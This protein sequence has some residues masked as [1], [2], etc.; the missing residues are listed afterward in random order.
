[1]NETELQEASTELGGAMFP[2]ETTNPGFDADSGQ[3]TA[4]PPAIPEAPGTPAQ[5][6]AEG[7]TTQAPAQSAASQQ[8]GDQPGTTAPGQQPTSQP[9]L[10]SSQDPNVAP[11]TWRKEAQAL[12]PS[13]P[14]AVREEFRKR[15]AD[16]S[17]GLQQ[18]RHQAQAFE[19]FRQVA[20]PFDR[21]FRQ[22]NIDPI[23]HAGE[24]F[25]VHHRL[26][27]GSPM[28]KVEVLQTLARQFGVDPSMVD[29]G[30]TP[31]E[32]PEA[33]FLRE[34]NRV[35]QNQI[36]QSQAIQ[37]RQVQSSLER[38]LDQFEA[39]PANV[40]FAKVGGQMAQLIASG[41]ANS[42]KDAYEKACWTNPEV[43]AVLLQQQQASQG[44]QS[45]Q[46]ARA[47]AAQ[48]ATRMNGS[49]QVLPNA[50]PQLQAGPKSIGQTMESTLDEILARGQ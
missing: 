28:E 4:T 13:L 5:P 47:R 41:Q 15:E 23:R 35:L 22:A 32:S 36:R 2:T 37:I 16:F 29:P 34:Q 25:A 46:Q 17:R 3:Q 9:P 39:D 6:A 48:A 44:Q 40:Y 8:P 21:E 26:L 12:W 38:E 24:L 19:N 18:F 10:P 14:L 11:N 27:T 20:A 33:K 45:Q 50:A 42:L 49:A 31:Y 1:M 7:N 43:R 30:N